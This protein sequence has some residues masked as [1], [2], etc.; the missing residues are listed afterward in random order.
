[1]QE[2][3]QIE[4]LWGKAG[5]RADPTRRRKANKSLVSGV[6]SGSP[7]QKPKHKRRVIEEKKEEKIQ[8]SLRDMNHA[9]LV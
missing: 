9:A 7:I 1:M 4:G 6:P 8:T 3:Q 2:A 5:G